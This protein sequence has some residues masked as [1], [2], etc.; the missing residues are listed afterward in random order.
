MPPGPARKTS[1]A[2][3]GGRMA[4]RGSGVAAPRRPAPRSSMPPLFSLLGQTRSFCE[5]SPAAVRRRSP[6]A[7]L[8]AGKA[9]PSCGQ[10][11]PRFI[12]L[13]LLLVNSSSWREG[14]MRL[15]GPL[16]TPRQALGEDNHSPPKCLAPPS[17]G[18]HNPK[19][20]G[21][22]KN[23]LQRELKIGILINEM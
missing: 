14:D 12:Y 16:R 7:F 22:K 10:P 20:L 11:P 15:L 4:A 19:Y 8:P 21:E 17:G 1:S 18:C 3:A 9:Q 23:K 2:G 6:S 13:F 5:L